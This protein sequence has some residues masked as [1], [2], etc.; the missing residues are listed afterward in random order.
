SAPL[1]TALLNYRHN[2]VAAEVGQANASGARVLARGESWTN[3]PVTLIV[4]DK[5]AEFVLTAQT[6]RRIDPHRTIGY[7]QAAL[8][9]LVHAL[10]HAPHTPALALSILPDEERREVI[11]RFNPAPAAD[12]PTQLIHEL[13]EAQ[14]RRT[15]EA[16]AAVYEGQS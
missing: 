6:D 2:A 4:D 12:T 13:F 5:G 15:P 14:A 9:S 7:L 11:E 10:E 8:Q 3:Y 16:I 1:F